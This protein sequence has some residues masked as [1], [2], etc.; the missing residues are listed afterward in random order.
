MIPFDTM[1]VTAFGL[2]L[3]YGAAHDVAARTVPNSLSLAVAL[4][5]LLQAGRSDTLLT[6]LIIAAAVFLIGTGLWRVGLLGGGD[7]KLMA[8]VS[9]WFPPH[10]QM[11]LFATTAML[12]GA[13]GCVYLLL[14]RLV[15]APTP[16]RSATMLG[17]LIRAELR[18]IRKRCALPYAVA[19]SSAALLCLVRA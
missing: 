15:P 6:N 12:G 5:G 18:R 1:M 2:L 17:R 13:L 4:L 16:R 10:A 9:L 3:A 14:S 11:A 8:A 7:V 19:I